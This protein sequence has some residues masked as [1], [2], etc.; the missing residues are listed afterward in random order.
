MCV[1]FDSKRDFSLPTVL[2]GFLCTWTWDISSKSLQHPAA[3]TPVLLGCRSSVAMCTWDLLKEVAIIFITSIIVWPQVD[4]RKGTQPH[5][6]RE[7]WIKDLL[8][9]VLPIRTKPSFPLSKSPPSVSFHKPFILLHQRADRLKNYNHRK[10][11]NLI[12][13]TTALSNS[14]KL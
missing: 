11:T 12:T 8:S 1:G 7:N 3:T 5:P 6:S 4:K 2:L 10:L 9:M 13:W 14:M